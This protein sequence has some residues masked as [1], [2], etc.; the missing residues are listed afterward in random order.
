MTVGMQYLDMIVV[1]FRVDNL[2]IDIKMNRIFS[3]RGLGFCLRKIGIFSVCDHT[4][5]A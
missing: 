3:R 2:R 4:G 5:E 1:S